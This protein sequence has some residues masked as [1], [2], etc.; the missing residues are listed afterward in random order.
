MEEKSEVR[1]VMKLDWRWTKNKSENSAQWHPDNKL[2]AGGADCIIYVWD[3]TGSDPSLVETLVG[4]TNCIHTLSFS[5]ILISSS[6]DKSIKFWKIGAS[7]TDP[8]GT[9]TGSTPPDSV[10]IMSMCLQASDGVAISVGEAG[11]V[12]TGLCKASF[13]TSA[14]PRSRRDIQLTDGK[15]IFVWCTQKKIHI[16]S[17]KKETAK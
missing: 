14:G 9:D 4:H 3:I 5:S 15:L 16:W 12:R 2:V 8:A 11:L 6:N 13:H 1:K 7:L 17:P 10:T